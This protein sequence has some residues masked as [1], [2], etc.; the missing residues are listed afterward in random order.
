M[1]DETEKNQEKKIEL[2]GNAKKYSLFIALSLVALSVLIPLVNSM[3]AKPQALVA[4]NPNPEPAIETDTA[5]PS[6]LEAFAQDREK[7]TDSVDATRS[8][9][10]SS[11]RDKSPASRFLD[12]IEKERSNL[13]LA[14]YRRSILASR[15]SWDL[16]PIQERGE[17]LDRQPRRSVPMMADTEVREDRLSSEQQRLN[18]KA[19]LKSL[20]ELKERILAGNYSVGDGEK[21]LAT[22]QTQFSEPPKEIVGFT[23]ENQYNASTEGMLVLPIGT[24]IPAVT[25]MKANSDRLGTFKALVSQDIMDVS[26]TWVLIPKGS[27]VI[28]KSFRMSGAN[29]AIN[30]IV[31]MSVPWI[32]LPDGRKIDTSK[33]SGLDREGM[34]GISDQVDHHWIEQFLG[35]AAYALV[36][37]NTSYEGTGDTQRS[38]EA[39]VSQGL[40]DQIA[41]HAQKYLQLRPTN[42]IRSGQ[43]MNIM[44]EDDVFLTPWRNIYEDYL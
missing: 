33:S 5:N 18:L 43:N 13:E 41:P 40:R 28:I 19:R 21:Q 37:N 29:E 38:Y 39:D 2:R 20:A 1:S 3:T 4:A 44:I 8:T 25:T 42:V 35:V 31:G 9:A 11:A 12:P 24:V 27:E 10:S 7:A 16:L 6:T 15:S 26:Q 34:G 32:V 30:S 22:I 36:A 14:E 23:D 17:S